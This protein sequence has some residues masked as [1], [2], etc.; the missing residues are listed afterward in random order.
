MANKIPDLSMISK[1]ETQCKGNLATA[2]YSLCY[3]SQRRPTRMRS[4][5]SCLRAIPPPSGNWR[6]ALT[7]AQTASSIPTD[8]LLK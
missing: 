4:V 2:K 6:A 5:F 7:Q 8:A 1:M 3:L